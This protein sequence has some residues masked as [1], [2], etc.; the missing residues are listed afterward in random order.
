MSEQCAVWVA[1]GAGDVAL[2]ERLMDLA[3]ELMGG[4]GHSVVAS[5]QTGGES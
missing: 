1:A 2:Q 4:I 5:K 3:I